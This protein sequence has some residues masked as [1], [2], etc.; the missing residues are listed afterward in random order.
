M[1]DYSLSEQDELTDRAHEN[2]EQELVQTLAIH[3]AVNVVLAM[4]S[5]PTYVTDVKLDRT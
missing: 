2:A 5:T 3:G 1:R 4:I